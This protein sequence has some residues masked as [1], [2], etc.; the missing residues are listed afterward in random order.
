LG[1]HKIT[2]DRI[3]GVIALSGIFDLTPVHEIG[4]Q[5][6]QAIRET[7][8][9]SFGALKSASPVTYV[10]ADAPKF[11]ILS[12]G[13]DFPGFALDA[14]EFADAFRR[15]GKREIDQLTVKGADHFSI[16]KFDDDNNLLRQAIFD[17][18]GMKAPPR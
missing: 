11:L 4:A 16:A 7:F 12:A 6:R 13:R 2:T 15:A 5:Q 8:D 10:R 1:R 9:R 18:M 17:L 3:A 14:R